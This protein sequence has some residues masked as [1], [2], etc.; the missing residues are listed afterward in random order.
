MR[1]IAGSCRSM[2][3]KTVPGSGTRPTTDRIKE[4]LFNILQSSVPNAVVADVFAGSGALGIEALSRG[5]RFAWFSDADRKAVQVIRENLEFTRLKDSARVL[6][7][8]YTDAIRTIASVGV[9]PDIV[10]LYPPY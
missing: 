2:P 4:T 1:V 9:C 10:F 5:S 8:N 3:L 6:H 7:M